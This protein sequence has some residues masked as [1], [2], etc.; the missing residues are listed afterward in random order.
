MQNSRIRQEEPAARSESPARRTSS[1]LARG[2]MYIHLGPFGTRK[3]VLIFCQAWGFNVQIQS[4]ALGPENCSNILPGGLSALEHTLPGD[5]DSTLQS[6]TSR[7]ATFEDA[8]MRWFHA[9]VHN[10]LRLLHVMRPM[11]LADIRE[12]DAQEKG[13]LTLGRVARLR[14]PLPRDVEWSVLVFR[15]LY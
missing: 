4:E 5:M 6:G 13:E 1:E 8:C 10:H 15:N 11:S 9:R 2:L 12:T 3:I 14:R 7:Q